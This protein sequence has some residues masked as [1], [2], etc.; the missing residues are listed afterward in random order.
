MQNLKADIEKRTQECQGML[1]EIFLPIKTARPFHLEQLTKF[2]QRSLAWYQFLI[3][4]CLCWN[5]L[6]TGSGSKLKFSKGYQWVQWTPGRL[7]S[8]EGMWCSIIKKLQY[9]R[10]WRGQILLPAIHYAWY[11]SLYIELIINS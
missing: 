6:I 3:P 4:F 7:L 10:G 2:S 8:K 5:C 1:S 9:H 11:S